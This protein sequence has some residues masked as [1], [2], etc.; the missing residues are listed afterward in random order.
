MGGVCLERLEERASVVKECG[1]GC[2]ADAES[3][4]PYEIRYGCWS[5]EWVLDS[6]LGALRISRVERRR[7]SP[8]PIPTPARAGMPS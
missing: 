6:S 5:N 3:G 8:G 4:R 7:G 1:D 2:T